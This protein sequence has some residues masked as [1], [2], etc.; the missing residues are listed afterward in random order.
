AVMLGVGAM[1]PVLAAANLAC[2]WLVR[3]LASSEAP[4]GLPPR[5]D[6][7]PDL[8]AQPARSG[9][10]VLREASY[11]RN[12]AVLVLLGTFAAALVDYAFKA[13]AVAA[14]G[15]GDGLLRFFAVYYS[16]VS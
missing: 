7:P 3:R 5:V 2:A 8:A 11:L 6:M 16:A 15:R 14:L 4:G 10:R 1:L 12:L 13:Q 9:L